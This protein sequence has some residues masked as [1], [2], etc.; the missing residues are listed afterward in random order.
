MQDPDYV[1]HFFINVHSLPEYL[2][3]KVEEEDDASLV[4]A[5]MSTILS[6]V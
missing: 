4:N 3:K 5:H 2:R 1:L 6:S